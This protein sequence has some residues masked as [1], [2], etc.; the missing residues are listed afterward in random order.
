MSEIE[1]VCARFDARSQIAEP[2]S[3]RRSSTEK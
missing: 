3:S 2:L 1:G